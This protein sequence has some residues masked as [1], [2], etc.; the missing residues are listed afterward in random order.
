MPKGIVLKYAKHL[1]SLVIHIP[2]LD[3]IIYANSH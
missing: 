1:A 3:Y 2:Y